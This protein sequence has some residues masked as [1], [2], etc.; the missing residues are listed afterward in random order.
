MYPIGEW[1]ASLWFCGNHCRKT[2][3][4]YNVDIDCGTKSIASFCIIYLLFWYKFGFY[5]LCSSHQMATLQHPL[6][7]CIQLIGQFLR[8][9]NSHSSS[10]SIQFWSGFIPVNEGGQIY[11]TLPAISLTPTIHLAQFFASSFFKPTL[12]LSLSTIPRYS[13]L[14]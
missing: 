2:K 11:P 10:S 5:Y 12:L 9:S 7:L 14:L 1:V 3:T 6:N 8:K 4:T 13:F